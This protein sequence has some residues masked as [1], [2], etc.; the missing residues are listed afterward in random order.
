V[1]ALFDGLHWH[2]RWQVFKN[3]FTPGHNPV[4]ELCNI[5][6][7]PTDLRGKR[8]LDIGAWHGCFSFECERRGAAEVVALTLESPEQTGFDRLHEAIGSRVVRHVQQSIYTAD[9]KEIGTFDVVL[10]LGVLYH[11]RYPLLALDRIRNLCTG[12][13]LVETHVLDDCFVGPNGIRKL[14]D[15]DPQLLDVPLWQFYKGGELGGDPSNWFAANI[16]GVISAFE[17]AGFAI[18]LKEKW[19]TRAAFVALSEKTLVESLSRTYEVFSQSN[20]DFIGAK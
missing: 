9:P 2:Q 18:H 14:K 11:L 10:F 13:C 1:S 8:V 17:S 12:I 20:L 15:V 5:I 16:S 7:L 19:S 6:G 4:E 3:V